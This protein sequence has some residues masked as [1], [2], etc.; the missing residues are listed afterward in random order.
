MPEITEM[1]LNVDKIQNIDRLLATL[2]TVR[3]SKDA[4]YYLARMPVNER[5]RIIDQL[6]TKPLELATNVTPLKRQPG[7]SW[8]RIGAYRVI[9]HMVNNTLFV[10]TVAPRGRAYR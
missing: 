4:F 10:D 7:M 5:V 6:A 2:M 3:Y 8:L 1:L 9:F